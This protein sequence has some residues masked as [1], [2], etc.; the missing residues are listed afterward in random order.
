MSDDPAMLDPVKT[1]VPHIAT[2]A[3]A[4]GGDERRIG[5]ILVDMGSLSAADAQRI[6]ARQKERYRSF[7][8]IACELGLIGALDLELALSRQFAYARFAPGAGRIDGSLVVASNP[9]SPFAESLRDLRSQLLLRWLDGSRDRRQIL[10]ASFD[11]GQGR[12]FIAA[13]LAVVFAQT[14]ERTLLIDADLRHP[15]QHRL[16]GIDAREGLST[17]LSELTDRPPV[18]RIPG[19]DALSVV[20]AGPLAPNPQELLSRRRTAN[21]LG[22]LGARFDVVIFDSSAA[23]ESA[24]VQMLARC[25]GAVLFVGRRGTAR[26]EGMCGLEA[27]CERAGATVVGSIFND[28]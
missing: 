20:P 24:D 18:V 5:A 2:G 23:C 19:I 15:S 12:S 3:H 27:D 25:T 11:R 14:G 7:G 17:W 16:F 21:R 8:E 4:R 22:E 28:F 9:S 13:N 1:D 10:T 6:L 26:I